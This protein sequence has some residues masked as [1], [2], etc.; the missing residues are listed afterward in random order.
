MLYA[1]CAINI[2]D[3]HHFKTTEMQHI[4]LEKMGVRTLEHDECL[5]VNGGGFWDFLMKEAIIHF[6]DLARGLEKGWNFDKKQK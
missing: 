2:K 1:L 6:D 5:A 3:E 4:E